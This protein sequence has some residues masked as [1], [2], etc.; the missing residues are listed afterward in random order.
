DTD[1][2]V[3][4]LGAGFSAEKTA[5][6]AVET[7]KSRRE[8]LGK[9]MEQMNASL[10]KFAQGMQALEAEATSMSRVTPPSPGRAF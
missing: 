8:Q 6:G 4:N 5:D 10:A 1:R 7:L 2:I 3:V 9:I